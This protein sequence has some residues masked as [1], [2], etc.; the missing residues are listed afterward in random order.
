MKYRPEIDG[1]RAFAVVPVVLYH[2]GIG[3]FSGGFV[4]VD[5]FFVIS[6]YL[7]TGIIIENVDRG[8]FSIL[9]F[10]SRRAR[11]ILP[12]LFVVSAATIPFAVAW[13]PK[14]LLETYAESLVATILSASNLYFW[15]RVD[16][17]DAGVQL[18][19]LLHTWSLGVEEHFYLFYPFILAFLWRRS[20]RYSV[21]GLALLF[22]ASLISAQ[23]LLQSSPSASF[24]LLPTRAWE[25]TAGALVAVCFA[26]HSFKAPRYLANAGTVLGLAAILAPV[27]L[28]DDEMPFP[29][30]AALPPVA[31][32][33]LILLVSSTAT[34]VRAILSNRLA[35]GLGLISYSAYL[36]HQPFIVFYKINPH[37]EPTGTGLLV[38]CLAA[39]A[40]AA[41]TYFVIEQPA[42]RS[43][44]RGRKLAGW[45][46]VPAIALCSLGLVIPKSSWAGMGQRE[47]YLGTPEFR[48]LVSAD[49]S[50][51]WSF[52]SMSDTNRCGIRMPE[53]AC[54]FGNESWIT[55]GDSFVGDME[56][57]LLEILT[58]RGEGMIAL[59]YEQCPFLLGDMWFGN[60][61]ECNIVNRERRKLIETLPPKTIVIGVNYGQFW[62]AKRPIVE[63]IAAGTRLERTQNGQSV[64]ENEAWEAFTTA[65]E[66]LRAKG[67]RVIVLGPR[68]RPDA[69]YEARAASQP[70]PE[71][72]RRLA[73]ATHVVKKS[74]IYGL[75]NLAASQKTDGLIFVDP[76]GI[77]CNDAGEDLLCRDFVASGGI[78]NGQSHFSS[79]G[80]ALVANEIVRRTE[81]IPLAA[82]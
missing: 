69:L 19:P 42:R 46:V 59:A 53:N 51:A 24:Y 70:S 55:L 2:A 56:P 13:L 73:S 77:F 30:L 48:K 81:N 22:L 34:S 26:R 33:A 35:V 74:S 68:P 21:A 11:R 4:G 7:I 45:V 1:L 62:R 50:K 65:L 79:I 28:Y 10:Y 52:I 44:I 40:L 80:A 12:A 31:G 61:P 17:F 71:M 38:V 18:Q 23:W 47:S 63:E 76:I 20:F 37:I 64:P 14:Q 67:H 16:Y 25:L 27:F 36:W 75:S 32:T 57:S 82:Q 6:G 9:D 72:L 41:A 58:A 15:W 3:G 66:W 49:G 78:Y 29:G 60:I 8:R 39:F 43:S 5:V 54:R